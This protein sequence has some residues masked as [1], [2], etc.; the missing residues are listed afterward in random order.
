MIWY[1]ILT[2]FAQTIEGFAG[3]GSTAMALPFLAIA[4]GT[5]EAV[6]LL[7]LNSL[8]SGGAICL[9]NLKQVN[10]REYLKITLCVLPFIPAGILLYST[11]ARYEAVLKLILGLT[12][13]FAG[14]RG[15]WYA[16]V[17]KQEP[18]ALGKL[19][20]Y[21]AL[22]AGALVQ[23][24]FNAGGPLIVLYANEQ[25]R[26]KGSFRATMTALWFTLNTLGLALRLLITDMYT[27][28]TFLTFAECLPV[29]A[30]GILIGM[31]L[32][33]RIDNARFKQGVYLIMLAGGLLSVVYC[34][35]GL[36]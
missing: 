6:A 22:F 1:Y 36:L 20:S 31:L 33:K 17:K 4:I 18:P 28:R 9:M 10:R 15:A 13:V 32:H 35:M 11:L 27:G 21:A 14:A 5:S 30:L 7:S 2:F 3:F 34:L 19:A 16:F 8:V 12:V 29:L 24:M 23:G 26:D 25:L